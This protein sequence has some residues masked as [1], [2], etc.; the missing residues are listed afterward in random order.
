MKLPD[1]TKSLYLSGAD[2][3][4]IVKKVFGDTLV[5]VRLQKR[6]DQ[7]LRYHVTFFNN[8]KFTY[9]RAGKEEPEW[10][11]CDNHEIIKDLKIEVPVNCDVIVDPDSPAE[12]NGDILVT[13][14]G[15]GLHFI[16]SE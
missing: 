12:E 10:S 4:E 14:K 1:H 13:G 5:E 3:V 11:M 7:D 16:W 15:G 8:L 2:L 9:I 6:E